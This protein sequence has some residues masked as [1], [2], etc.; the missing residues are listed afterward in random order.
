MRDAIRIAIA[1]TNPT[2]GVLH[3]NADTVRMIRDDAAAQ[4][5]DLVVFSELIMSG[6]PPE[7][8]V[9]RKSF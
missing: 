8:L 1:Q 4:G 6:Y 5:A 7:D 9:L 3:L 2:V